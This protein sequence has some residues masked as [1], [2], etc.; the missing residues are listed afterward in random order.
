MKTVFSNPSDI[1]HIWANETQ[2]EARYSGGNFFFMDA[3]IYSYGYHFP[4][5][6]HTKN[7]KG[8]N[9]ILF[10]KRG[11][12]N[13]T[14]KHISITR[15]A[16]NHKN[17]IYCDRPTNSHEENFKSWIGEIENIFPKLKTARK[18]KKYL[19]EI[20]H[21]KSEVNKYASFFDAKP[22][23]E[24]IKLMAVSDTSEYVKFQEQKEKFA[25]KEHAKE[26]K[27]QA[28]KHKEELAKFR[29]FEIN[30]MR[31]RNDFDYLRFRNNRFETSQG[32]EIP[33]QIGLDIWAW[34][35][36]TSAKG[37][38]T[39]CNK[40]ILRYDVKEVTKKHIVVGCH[41]ITIKEL[42]SAYK[43]VTNEN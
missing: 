41:K 4:I 38:C 43:L 39:K 19:L 1:A 37:G 34:I 10:T 18:P 8:E 16:C 20:D 3:I 13:T 35:K 28:E 23:K 11:Y 26:L 6:K 32:V 24:L 2:N 25:A 42:E 27:Q 33:K 21:L 22:P 14:A 30:T 5:A 31:L 40:T 7:A 36:E 15:N 9:A 12:S 17:V 29:N